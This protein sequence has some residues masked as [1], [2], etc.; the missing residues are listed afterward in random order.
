MTV[1]GEGPF[2][3]SDDVDFG[4][5]RFMAVIRRGDASET[6]ALYACTSSRR[7]VSKSYD[8]KACGEGELRPKGTIVGVDTV[9]SHG[10][11]ETSRQPPGAKYRR[12]GRA[13]V[14]GRRTVMDLPGGTRTSRSSTTSR[15]RFEAE[16]PRHPPD[17]TVIVTQGR[18]GADRRAGT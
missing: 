8:K 4:S 11:S 17:R 9:D 16:I 12:S 1:D 14:P 2:L 3:M 18:H 7:R 5:E 6:S 15:Q 10:G 13:P